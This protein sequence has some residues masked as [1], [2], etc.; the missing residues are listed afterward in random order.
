M[1]ATTNTLYPRALV[2][3]ATGFIGGRLVKCLA[4]NG[5]EVH[6]LTRERQ[7]SF[8]ND[9]TCNWHH[10]DRTYESVSKAIVSSCADVVFHLATLFVSE[11]QPADI[12]GLVD[13]NL[14]FGMQLL[15]AMHQNDVKRLVNT[16]TNWQH[17]N[18]TGYDPANLYAATKQAF[19]DVAEFYVKAHNFRIVTLEIF[20]TFGEGDTRIKLLNLLLT[21]ARNDASI[22]LSPGDQELSLV[23]VEDITFA[24]EIVAQELLRSRE[25]ATLNTYSLPADN[26]F[27]VKKLVT[28]IEEIIGRKMKV[29]W[30][31]R[32][33]RNREVMVPTQLFQRPPSW[34]QKRSLENFIKSELA[35]SGAT[36]S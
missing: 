27:S 6:A 9:K 19:I 28:I 25:T 11:H 18:G 21:A 1:T 22:D 26:F 24:F 2:T 36:L 4:A 15:E 16:G 31:G 30:G 12:D 33:Y 34:K 8:N 13:A 14:R 29:N 35:G 32:Q 23:H 17:F 3:G 20:D 10:Y 7:N 5:W